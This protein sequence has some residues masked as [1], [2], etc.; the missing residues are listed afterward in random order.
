MKVW[1]RR[2]M[3]DFK[4]API[5]TED[6][7][8]LIYVS[9]SDNEDSLSRYE[10]KIIKSAALQLHHYTSL[11]LF[12]IRFRRIAKMALLNSSLHKWRQ[13]VKGACLA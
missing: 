8:K 12:L 2:L 3:K 9:P 1:E 7:E 6:M 10:I 4:V 5:N 11:I 13:V